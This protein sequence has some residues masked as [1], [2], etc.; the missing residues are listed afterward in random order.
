MSSS[1]SSFPRFSRRLHT[2]AAPVVIAAVLAVGGCAATNADGPASDGAPTVAFMVPEN[3]NPKWQKDADIFTAELK[4]ANPDAE[5]LFFSANNDDS[6]QQSQFETALTKGA[7]VVVISA[8]DSASSAKLA[9]RAAQENVPVIAFDHQ[10]N[11][12]DKVALYVSPDGEVQGRITGEYVAANTEPGD[13]IMFLNGSPT[14][15]NA[16]LYH[17]GYHGVLDPMI[18]SGERAAAGEEWTTGWDPQIAQ[19]NVEQLLTTSQNQ[20]DALVVPW[21]DG[22]GVAAAALQAQS[23]TGR[24]L[25]TGGDATTA[26]LQ[27]ILLGTQTMTVLRDDREESRIAAQAAAGLLSDNAVPEDLI[28]GTVDNGA[29]QIP[30]ALLTPTVIDIDNIGTLVEDG[31]VSK[32]ELCTGIAAGVGP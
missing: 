9:E 32:D 4:M 18:A 7:S 28:T 30:A 23:L 14:D 31:W 24:V 20:V 17:Q 21:D 5:V 15:N 6:V 25:V 19:R 3:V 8:V 1:V 29:G 2:R 12:T 22:A 16:T 27:R 10:I 11:N 13:R 26:A